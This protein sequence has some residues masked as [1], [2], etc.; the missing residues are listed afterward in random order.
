MPARRLT[1]DSKG[2]VWAAGYFGNNIMMVDPATGKVTEYTMPLK[3]GNPYDLWPDQDDN[4]WIENA[5][6]DSLVKFDPRTKNFT[7]FPFP[8]LSAHT[9]KLDRDKEGT[10]WFTLGKPSTLA[11]FKPKGNIA[12]RGGATQ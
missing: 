10:F 3:Y 6:Y 11:G 12:S 9:P 4:I 1:I 5:V 2:L 8:E 7:Y